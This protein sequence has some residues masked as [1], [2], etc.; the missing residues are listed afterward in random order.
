MPTYGYG[1]V[2]LSS[3]MLRFSPPIQI[4]NNSDCQARKFSEHYILTDAHCAE[5]LYENHHSIA[6]LDSSGV[7]IGTIADTTQDERQAGLLRTDCKL[8]GSAPVP[9]AMKTTP[10]ND[11]LLT[12]YY[13]EQDSDSVV[14]TDISLL[15]ST[16]SEDDQSTIYTVSAQ[17]APIGSSIG[18]WDQVVCTVASNTTCILHDRVQQISDKTYAAWGHNCFQKMHAVN[19]IAENY[20]VTFHSCRNSTEYDYHPTNFTQQGIQGRGTAPNPYWK[21]GT[22]CEVGI[23]IYYFNTNL[24]RYLTCE[25]PTSGDIPMT[26]S[27]LL[28]LLSAIY[29]IAGGY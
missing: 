27:P 13:L 9:L 1:E 15:S 10:S 19:A 11:A 12:A 8:P 17:T 22:S 23:N 29:P 3:N 4:D 14:H 6:I 21:N 26:I 18:A 2:I 28:I 16:R 25:L 20:D 7:T 24:P 5:L